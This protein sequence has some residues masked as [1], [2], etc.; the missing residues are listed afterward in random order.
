MLSDPRRAILASG[1]Q[2]GEPQ[3]Q[4]NGGGSSR[5]PFFGC[6]VARKVLIIDDDQSIRFVLREVLRADG[7]AVDEVEDGAA[8]EDQLERQRYDLLMLDLYMPGMNG[9]EVLRRIRQSHAAVL[10]IWKT[11]PT[12]GI[13]VLSG[14]AGNEGLSFAARL[15]AD[16]CLRKPL[17]LSDVIAAVRGISR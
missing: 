15:G 16:I 8:V 9:F 1:T 3:P 11:P 13:I 6:L 4:P 7:W 12:V 5:P 10:P 17:E 2:R 14:A